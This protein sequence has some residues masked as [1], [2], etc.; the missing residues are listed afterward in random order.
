MKKRIALI[1][2]KLRSDIQNRTEDLILNPKTA[3]NKEDFRY[4]CGYLAALLAIEK[5]NKQLLEGEDAL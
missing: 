2:E 5:I 3:E 1:Q 4:K